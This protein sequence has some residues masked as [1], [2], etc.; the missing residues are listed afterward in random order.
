MDFKFNLQRRTYWYFMDVGSFAVYFAL[1]DDGYSNVKYVNSYLEIEY[2]YF[3]KEVYI[4]IYNE[5]QKWL[6]I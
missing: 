2:I 6:F 1:C 5:N 4:Y 3:L